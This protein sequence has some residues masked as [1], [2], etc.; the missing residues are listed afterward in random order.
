MSPPHH[1]ALGLAET[2]K[3][4]AIEKRTPGATIIPIII[5]SDKTQ[6]TVF[7]SKTAYPIYMTI[8][9]LLKDVR[10][11]PSRRGQIL[12]AYLPSSNLKHVTNKAACRRT[13]ANLFHAYMGLVLAPLK[14]AGFHGIELTS[15]DGITRRRHPI[16]AMYIG[17]YPE[18]L[19]VTCCKNGT[20]P[21]CDVA[22]EDIG[23]ASDS[24]RTRGS[25]KKNRS[26]ALARRGAYQRDLDQVLK[27]LDGY[28]RGATAFSQACRDAGIKPVVNPFWKDL[29]NADIFLS[30]TPD[31]L[32]QLYQGVMKHLLSWLKAAYGPEEID[33]RCRRLPPNHQIRLF[34]K[35]VTT[36]Q[37]V[38]GK[39]H[40]DICRFLL[41]LIIGLLLADALTRFHSNKDIFVQLGVR[42]HFK[43]PKLHSL[44][45]YIQSIKLFGT[46]DNYDTQYTERLHIDLAKD[47]YRATNR[48]DEF[49]Q[50]TTWL[51]RREKILRHAAYID[52]R[53]RR[54]ADSAVDNARS[55]STVQLHD[56]RAG[57]RSGIRWTSIKIAKWPN[58]KALS[59]TDAADRYGA[60]FLHDA[61]ARFVVQYCDPSLT[62]REVEAQ[63]LSVSFR[64]NKVQV[65]HKA[66]FLLQDAQDLG[67]MEDVRDVAHARP[68]RKDKQG[69]TVPGRFDAVLVNDGTGGRTGTQGYEVAQ[70]RLIFKLPQASNA[71][72]FPDVL[73]PGY[74]A[75]IKRFSPLVDP[76][77]THGL[78]K[79]TRLR[80]GRA[81]TV[82]GTPRAWPDLT[83]FVE[84]HHATLVNCALALYLQAKPREADPTASHVV[85]FRLR[86]RADPVLAP[87]MQFEP[88]ALDLLHRRQAD[89][90]ERCLRECECAISAERFDLGSRY[91]T[92][93]AYLILVE[94]PHLAVDAGMDAPTVALWKHF[95]VDDRR[96]KTQPK[97]QSPWV[98]FKETVDGGKKMRFCCGE[99]ADLMVVCSCGGWSHM[100][101][102]Q[103]DGLVVEGR[104]G[105]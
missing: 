50:M 14:D 68:Q 69:R 97:E 89:V 96:W 95:G 7:G 98:V 46:T 55:A 8:G 40:A 103:I 65:Y 82:C 91:A 52:W 38:T 33:A 21:K 83:A 12:L 71:S 6:L 31:L 28:D 26:R 67:I 90:L 16:F 84:Y 3:R 93:G 29:P 70:L 105:I 66:K 60:V 4:I 101:G 78:H 24:P 59:F 100:P 5:S 23:N 64:F 85:Q 62:A 77:P 80:D 104:Y 48:K 13:L 87:H 43:L 32:H 25:R 10:H 75:Y 92:T 54:I 22:R 81:T 39:E 74:L 34:L 45:H 36:L 72:L 2:A 41:G 99:F 11:K 42:T 19:L 79:V 18:Q 37:R 53:L 1:E 57:S 88:V 17:D 58:V 63:S 27:A 9:N 94:Y 73:A 44:D 76:D 35:G 20:C 86:Y 49:P 47:A 51:E 56:A 61:L 15:G 102:G 30:I